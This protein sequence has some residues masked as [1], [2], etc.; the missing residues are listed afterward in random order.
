[1]FNYYFDSGR[2]GH[3]DT[4]RLFEAIGVGE[5]AGFTSEYALLELRNTVYEPKRNNMLNLIER[6]NIEMLD[7]NPEVN[8]LAEIYMLNKIIPVRYRYDSTHIAAASVNKMDCIL[9]YNFT[10]INREKTKLLVGQVNAIEGYNNIT[11]CTSREVLD[12][13]I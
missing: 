7:Y 3:V 5:Y 6:Y 8:R 4:V 13:E 12:G 11:I 2:D 9:S 1:M 10:H